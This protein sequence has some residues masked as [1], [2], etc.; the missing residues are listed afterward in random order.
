MMEKKGNKKTLK[1]QKWAFRS[2][3][4]F[5]IFLFVWTKISQ[6]MYKVKKENTVHGKTKLKCHDNQLTA[7]M[8]IYQNVTET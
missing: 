4:G 3:W 6:D 2:L 8:Q 5:F 1:Q 7:Q